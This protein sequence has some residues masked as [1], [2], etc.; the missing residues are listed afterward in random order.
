M[1]NSAKNEDSNQIKNPM[2]ETIRKKGPAFKN[3]KLKE[4]YVGGPGKHSKVSNYNS[5]SI[6]SSSLPQLQFLDEPFHNEH[7]YRILT[8]KERIA[9]L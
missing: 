4:K 7:L 8:Q 6:F 3:G 9:F 2:Y 1:F 5:S